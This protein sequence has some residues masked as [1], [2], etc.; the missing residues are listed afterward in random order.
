MNHDLLSY[1][2]PSKRNVICAHNGVVATTHPYAA[3]AGLEMLR[4]GG[5]AIDAAVA[6][7]AALTVVEPTSNGIGGDLF[8]L[9][10]HNGKLFGLNGSGVSPQALTMECLPNTPAVEIPKF[11][12]I[13]VT[14]PGAPRAWA[15][16][17]KR[18]GAVDFATL[19]EPAISYARNGVPV[20]PTV[21]E[22][23]AR[24]WNVYSQLLTDTLFHPWFTTFAPQG[25]APYVGELFKSES[26]AVTLQHIAASHAEDFYTGD[27]AKAILGFSHDT[28]GFFTEKD[29]REFS[30]LW[31]EP[32]CVSY[33]GYEIWELPPNGH[34]ITALM[35]LNMLQNDEFSSPV[36]PHTVHLQIESIK[37]SFMDAFTHISDPRF[38]TVSCNELLADAYAKRCRDRIT[39]TAQLPDNISPTKGGT[40]YCA[41]A[42]KY[43]NMV[44]LIQSNYMGFGSGLV[45]PNTGIALHNRGHNFCITPDHPNCIGPG[46][47]PYHTIIPGFITKNS[48]AVGPFGVMGG[49][50]QPQGH[51]QVVMNLIDFGMNPQ[52]ALDRYR[53]M[54]KEGLCVHFEKG[55]S[56]N[57][58]KKLS[59]KGHSVFIPVGAEDFGRGQIILRTGYGTYIAG[60]EKR[61]DGYIACY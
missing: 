19:F 10:W 39:G 55:H 26:H 29:F 24:A 41:T 35:A 16:L 57:L 27:L 59:R 61:A 58:L 1:A 37:R 54:W 3:Q 45:V 6:A 42:D 56:S 2:Y 44:S 13:P 21:G 34:G 50:M 8:A 5:N 20:Q 18:F 43:G 60:T 40:V 12:W 51:L 48:T 15:A 32:I 9:V 46:K 47:R 53:W 17:S 28:G 52:E 36:S 4:R 30:V 23:W 33:K 31:V 38:M 49:F 11:G 22:N 7:A 14:V 25:R